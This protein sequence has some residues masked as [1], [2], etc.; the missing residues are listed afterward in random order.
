MRND[1]RH[2]IAATVV[3]AK[4]L[5]QKAPDGRDRTEHSV[6]I[7]DVMFIKNF[8]NTRLSQ[9]VRERQPLIAREAGAHRVQARH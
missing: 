6:P 5:T 4:Y 7:R 8:P 9:N 2:G 1:S 3:S